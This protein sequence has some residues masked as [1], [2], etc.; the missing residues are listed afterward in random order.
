MSSRSFLQFCISFRFFLVHFRNGIFTILALFSLLSASGIMLERYQFT[1]LLYIFKVCLLVIHFYFVGLLSVYTLY[2]G[3]PI[4]VDRHNKFVI[5]SSM[6]D[7]PHFLVIF[8]NVCKFQKLPLRWHRSI[9]ALVYCAI[10]IYLTLTIWTYDF[11]T[12][13]LHFLIANMFYYLLYYVI[14]KFVHGE[15]ALNFRSLQPLL[16]LGLS[17]GVAVVSMH[18]FEIDLTEW[19]KSAAYSREG[20]DECI[21]WNFYDEHD[22]W[23]MYSSVAIFFL[24]M[25]LLTMDDGVQNVRQDQLKL[26]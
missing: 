24:Y 10:N 20:N 8:P 2:L 19:R 25:T 18:Y 26:I 17:V 11:A 1:L 4:T 14:V 7:I 6:N 15:F 21:L 22:I 9:S 23:H 5:L 16:Y 13:L 3:Y 12:L